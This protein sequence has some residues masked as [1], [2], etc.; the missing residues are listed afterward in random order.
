MVIAVELLFS[1]KHL[2]WFALHLFPSTIGLDMIGTNTLKLETF[3]H[4]A[5]N[6]LHIV[7]GLEYIY[8]MEK[9]YYNGAGY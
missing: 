2:L 1:N 6:M 3:L 5:K 4:F 7:R 8:K 9:V